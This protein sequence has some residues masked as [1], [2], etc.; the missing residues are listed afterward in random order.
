MQNSRF[1]IYLEGEIS[2]KLWMNEL[3]HLNQF[4]QPIKKKKKALDLDQTLGL[5]TLKILNKKIEYAFSFKKEIVFSVI[6]Q[7]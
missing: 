5:I 3:Q 6:I 1:S 7:N 2:G 4:N